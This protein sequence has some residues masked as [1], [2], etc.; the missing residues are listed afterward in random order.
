MLNMYGHSFPIKIVTARLPAY[1]WKPNHIIAAMTPLST[2][3][4]I[5]PLVPN[6]VLSSIVEGIPYFAPACPPKVKIARLK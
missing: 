4:M 6:D 5:D 1:V 2:P 3:G